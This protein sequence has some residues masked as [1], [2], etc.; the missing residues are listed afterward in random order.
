MI[1]VKASEVVELGTPDS[2]GARHT[3]DE[4]VA[5][6][7]KTINHRRNIKDDESTSTN[8]SHSLR[9]RIAS[10]FSSPEKRQLDAS[11][12]PIR[13]VVDTSYVT[14]DTNQCTTTPKTVTLKDGPF[15][16]PTSDFSAYGS[17]S[18]FLLFRYACTAAD[19]VDASLRNLI[20]QNIIPTAVEI[21]ESFLLVQSQTKTYFS[22]AMY[23][24]VRTHPINLPLPA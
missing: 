9:I 7:K 11:W 18:F 22:E 5:R 15:V 14:S 2:C 3:H 16:P 23:D 17:N 19:V 13:I 21:L 20:I 1:T 8:Q 6:L 10:H 12:K 24:V 4:E